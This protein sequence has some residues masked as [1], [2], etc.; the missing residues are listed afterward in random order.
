M[1][2]P[3]QLL[4]QLTQL[5]ALARSVSVL[6]HVAMLLAAYALW[7]AR[8]IPSRRVAAALSVLPVFSAAGLAVAGQNPFNAMLLGTTALV[9]ALLGARLSS[10]PVAAGSASPVGWGADP[11]RSVAA[12]MPRTT[13]HGVA[14]FPRAGSAPGW[15]RSRGRPRAGSARCRSPVVGSGA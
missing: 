13:L 15:A 7:S 10:R 6:W 14:L 2:S 5:S 9:M 12:V 11:V 3:E 8:W 4:A 1:P